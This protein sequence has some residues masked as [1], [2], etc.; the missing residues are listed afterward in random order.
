MN[1]GQALHAAA[2]RYCDEQH[3]HWCRVY[4]TLPNDGRESG[5]YHYTKEA[6]QTF[7]RYNV[8]NAIRVELDRID[9]ATLQRLDAARELIINVGANA[10][11]PFTQDPL[12]PIDANAI[13]QERVAFREFVLGL[14]EAD[15]ATIQPLLYKRTLSGA[16]SDRLWEELRK[17]WGIPESHWYPLAETSVEGIEAFQAPSFYA[18]YS[19]GELNKLL[20]S[21]GV[22]RLW[23]LREHGP[24][25]EEELSVFDP[26]YNGA[27]GYWSSGDLDWIIYASHESSI[28]IGG[29]LLEDVKSAWPSWERRIW[30][31]QFGI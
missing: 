9:P 30:T 23:E 25:Y 29:W 17:R 22:G 31:S 11:D 14:N 21:R 13:S 1:S 7:P 27:E 16:E 4:S 6:L 2:R 15:L 5:G 18:F 8:L 26:F 20:A 24:E 19:S 28:T 10:Q 3:A 12:G